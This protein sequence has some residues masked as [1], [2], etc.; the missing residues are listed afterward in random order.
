MIVAPALSCGSLLSA[1]TTLHYCR[2]NASIDG[3][4]SYTHRSLLKYI[5]L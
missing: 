2:S 4:Y 5:W 1:K 3:F